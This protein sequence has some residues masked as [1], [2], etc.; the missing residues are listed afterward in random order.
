MKV[1][2]TNDSTVLTD[3]EVQDALPAF[4]RQGY[5][6]QNWWHFQVPDLVWGRPQVEEA[7]QI[8]ILDDSD[9]ASALAYHDYTPGGRPISKVFAKTEIDNGYSWTVS[10][11]HEWLEMISDPWCTRGEYATQTAWYATEVAD[12]VEDDQ[13][14]Y[15]IT[16]PGHKPVLVSDFVLPY[17]F[18]LSAK[19]QYDFKGHCTQP[20]QILIGGYAIVFEDG[21]WWSYNFKGERLDPSELPERQRIH[22]YAREEGKNLPSDYDSSN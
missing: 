4:H 2:V 12:P 7:W 22:F 6:L 1:Y 5:H 19:G 15:E 14:G 9:Q 20:L 21:Q 16:I 11:S 8:Q 13:F 18:M 10:F 3:E 17:W